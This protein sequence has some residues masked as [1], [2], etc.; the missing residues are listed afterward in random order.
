[1]SGFAQH[2]R[3]LVNLRKFMSSKM[4]AVARK[5]AV[6]A[7]KPAPVDTKAA[8]YKAQRSALCSRRCKRIEK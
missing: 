3:P 4:P 2:N 7:R 8:L 6:V 1:M 5:P